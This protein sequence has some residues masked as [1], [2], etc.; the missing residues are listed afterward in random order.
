MQLTFRPLKEQTIVITGASSGI[1]LA[2]ARAAAKAGAKL[3]LAARNEEAL[4]GISQDLQAQDGEVIHVAADVGRREDVQRI[5][6]EAIARFGGFD[7]WINDAG[8]SIFGRIEEISDEDNQ[9]M[10]QTNFWGVVYGSLVAVRHLKARGG[11]LI[12]LGS[13]ASDQAFPMQGMYCA[14]KH[15]I[16]GFTD[17]L[18]MELKSEQAPIS[19]TL[20]K[21]AAID[22]PFPQHARN[23]MNEEPKLPPPVY[24][25]EE[26][27]R[28]IL[29]AAT[30]EKRE[31]NVGGGGKVM[32][33]VGRVAPRAM[34]RIGQSMI[35][36]QQR[37]E[38]AWNPQGALHHAGDDGRT[39]GDHPGFVMR[40]SFY[41]R[42]VLNPA[43]TG[44]LVAAAG[45][46]AAAI[47]TRRSH[48]H[49]TY[50][51]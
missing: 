18:R 44:A 43:L 33:M 20:I 5:A 21:P 8:V 6:D 38:P 25:V 37:S 19:V 39:R 15:A 29:Y 35:K 3:V 51:S 48:A 9:R 16:K 14:S 12:N 11:T 47:M 28:A 49:R 41:T 4:A 17:A 1:G 40:R 13:V 34:D 7:T 30:H 24:A 22:T 31:I 23:Y 2:T 45:V 27:A 50:D 10:F 42:S 32:T 26:V 36:Q 46:A